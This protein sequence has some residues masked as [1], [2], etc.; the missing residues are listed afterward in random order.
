MISVCNLDISPPIAAS[1]RGSG[2]EDSA[3]ANA[4]G[5]ALLEIAL[6]LGAAFSCKGY[7][8]VGRL[9]LLPLMSRKTINAAIR[10]PPIAQPTPTP[11]AAPFDKPFEVEDWWGLGFEDEDDWLSAVPVE[12]L[13]ALAEAA[14]AYKPV[15]EAGFEEVVDLL[16]ELELVVELGEVVTCFG[17]GLVATAAT[18]L[19]RARG[20][21]STS[22][23][24]PLPP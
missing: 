23:L 7:D 21:P 4:P 19:S 3:M 9:L 17:K 11:A 12:D 13:V 15:A 18:E 10:A 16:A 1:S 8:L 5:A 14:E 6:P 24:S 20:A 2:N 22:T